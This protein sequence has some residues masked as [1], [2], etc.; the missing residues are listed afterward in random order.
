MCVYYPLHP[1]WEKVDLEQEKKGAASY[2]NSTSLLL[3]AFPKVAGEQCA[4]RGSFLC[5]CTLELSRDLHEILAVNIRM[6][7]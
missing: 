6:N 7:V 3:P 4:V 5:T 2:K 1:G